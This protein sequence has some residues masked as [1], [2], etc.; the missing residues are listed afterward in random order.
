MCRR[1]YPAPRG[2]DPTPDYL[3]EATRRALRHLKMPASR[4]GLGSA[5]AFLAVAAEPS[6]RLSVRVSLRKIRPAPKAELAV[7]AKNLADPLAAE[8][9]AA[10]GPAPAEKTTPGLRIQLSAAPVLASNEASAC[11]NLLRLLSLKLYSGRRLNPAA[12]SDPNNIVTHRWNS[13][14]KLPTCLCSPGSICSGMP[15]KKCCMWEKPSP[16]AT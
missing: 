1:P 13:A 12:R 5:Q 14:K 9:F 7:D 11:L 3:Q 2:R 4:P 6:G 15:P 10:G 16:Y 8:A